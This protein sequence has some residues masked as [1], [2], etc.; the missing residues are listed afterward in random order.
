MTISDRTTAFAL[1][2]LFL[3]QALLLGVWLHNDTRPLRWDDAVHI[4]TALDYKRALASGELGALLSPK[5]RPGHPIYPPVVHFGMVVALFAAD[6]TGV[7]PE[8]AA[9]FL[10][11][12]FLALIGLGAWWLAEFWW[13]REAGLAA[14]FIAGLLP[15]FVLMS[16][17]IIVDVALAAFAVWAY[18]FWARGGRFTDRRLTLWLAAAFALGCLTKWSFPFY[19][20]PILFDAAAA[21][22]SGG[23][24]RRNVLCAAGLSAALLLPW[25]AVN[26]PKT[27]TRVLKA[28][29][30]GG[31]EGDPDVLSLSALLWYPRHAVLPHMT[32]LGV[33]AALAGAVHIFRRKM[34]GRRALLLWALSGYVF[35][36]LVSNKNDRYF[37]PVL[38][39]LALAAAA[40]PRR[41]PWGVAGAAALFSAWLTWGSA[42]SAWAQPA[43]GEAW[44][45]EQIAQEVAARRDKS[46]PFAVLTI[47]ANHEYL[48]GN[49]TRWTV[50]KL[51]LREAVRPR[52]KLVPFGQMTE[53]V[54][55]KT[56]DLGPA[57]AVARQTAVREEALRPGGWFLKCFEDVRRWPLPD[58]S[59][60]VLYRRRAAPPAE[61]AVR[62]EEALP[63]LLGAARFEG[64]SVSGE[65]D[66]LSVR[67]DS[68]SMKG[69]IIKGVEAEARG[70]GAVRPDEG[71]AR[72]LTLRSVRLLS[73]SVD[74]ATLLEFLKAKVKGLKDASV[75]ISPGGRIEVSGRLS[76]PVRIALSAAYAASPAPSLTARIESVRL[77]GIPLPVWL[78]G[79][80]RVVSAPLAAHAGMPFDVSLAGLATEP[81]ML[82]IG[83]K[84]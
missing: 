4:S 81:G 45:L 17:V 60:A 3:W 78:L 20:L 61:V 1:G 27:L 55:L 30:Q 57:Y 56:G 69:L 10:N 76:V 51:D 24:A 12:V 52:S 7:A 70:F 8:D 39:A 54:V 19:V 5:S 31:A 25:Y 13:G 15:G 44:P 63:L 46:A 73:A 33:L 65:G 82:F 50:E 79:G 29:G 62:P 28:A 71:G 47:L 48:N 41:I 9:T 67:A 74:E 77:A 38:P 53:F 42:S 59:E 35:W 68:V 80:K 49:N 84:S 66:V 11:L 58:G 6:A 64:L 36:T 16:R 14:A 34:E 37:M 21:A 75:S 26:I 83:E 32:W 23:A 2:A 22:W 43:R 40:L 72:V 18:A